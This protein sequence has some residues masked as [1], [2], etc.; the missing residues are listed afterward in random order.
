MEYP[1]GGYDVAALYVMGNSPYRKI[2]G[3]DCWDR[4]RDATRYQGPHPIVAHPPCRAWSAF[5]RHRAS[6]EDRHLAAVALRQ[7]RQFG[8]VLEHPAH[9]RFWAAAQLPDP[10]P[11]GQM[12]LEDCPV[13]TIAIDQR[14]FGHCAWK[15]T[16]LLLINIP[17]LKINPPPPV[18]RPELID[19]WRET[20][21]RRKRRTPLEVHSSTLRSRSPT[22]FANWL[23]ELA[24]SSTG[25]IDGDY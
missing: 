22:A 15:R 8:G 16:W 10:V 19:A 12:F 23:V 11:A 9:S 6:Q 13:K 4:R 21:G 24:R 25:G 17:Q 2:P 18:G 14:R 7:V 3:V 1:Q 20:G 5:L